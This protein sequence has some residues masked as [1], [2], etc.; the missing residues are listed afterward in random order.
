[1]QHETLEIDQ[2]TES[3]SHDEQIQFKQFCDLA[4]KARIG[5]RSNAPDPFEL[6]REVGINLSS[7][8]KLS[9]LGPHVWV[10]FLSIYSE[11]RH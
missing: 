3:L 11:V 1:M 6:A 4:G 2:F 7:L 8:N 5:F 10:A 9:S